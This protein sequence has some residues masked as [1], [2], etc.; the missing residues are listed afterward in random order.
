M[1]KGVIKNYVKA[2]IVL[3]IFFIFYL[4]NS[5]FFKYI[6]LNILKELLCRVHKTRITANKDNHIDT[7]FHH[8]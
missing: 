5:R 3:L 8:I 4:L 6:N 2:I 1:R 7:L